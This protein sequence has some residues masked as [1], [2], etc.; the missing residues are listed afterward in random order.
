M[1]FFIIFIAIIFLNA[2]S[3]KTVNNIDNSNNENSFV[4][5]GRIEIYGNEPFTY[6]GI[7]DVN[8]VAYNVEPSSAAN[9]LRSMQGNLMEFTVIF[10]EEQIKGY[11]SLPGGTVTPISWKIIR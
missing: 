1:K 7:V 3:C 4:I 2:F 10:P 11:G 5:T 9:E 6:V 8:N